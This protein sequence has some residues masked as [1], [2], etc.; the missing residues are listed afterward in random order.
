MLDALILWLLSSILT[1]AIV[2]LVL[3]IWT[4]PPGPPPVVAPLVAL[5]VALLLVL[6]AGVALPPVGGVVGQVAA[7]L[8]IGWGGWTLAKR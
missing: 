2:A 7:V 3:L 1:A 8:M 4:R 5:I 6:G